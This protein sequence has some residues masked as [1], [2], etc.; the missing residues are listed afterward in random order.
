MIELLGTLVLNRGDLLERMIA[1][2]DYPIDKLA[3]VQNSAAEDVTVAVNK[4]CQTKHKFINSIYVDRP[5]RNIGCGP[6]WNTIIKAFPECTHWL[7]A[8]NDHVFLPGDLLKFHKM[9]SAHPTSFITAQTESFSAF[10]LPSA[11]VDKVGLF[12]ENIWPIYC[13]DLDYMTRLRKSNIDILSIDS[14]VGET[15]NGSWTIRSNQTY[16]AS[17]NKTQNSNNEYMQRKWG[18][19]LEFN[20]PFNQNLPI[21]YWAYNHARRNEHSRYWQNFEETANKYTVQEKQNGSSLESIVKKLNLITDKFPS[22]S[23]CEK[24]YQT[25]LEPYRNRNIQILEIG[26]DQGGGLELFANYLPQAHVLGYDINYQG[27]LEQLPSLYKNITVKL[28]N[29]YDY[30]ALSITPACDII[31][32]SG[33]HVLESQ[34]FFVKNY[35]L[36]LK[37]GGMLIVESIA[38]DNNLALIKAHVPFHLQQYVQVYDFRSNKKSSDDLL[39]VIQLPK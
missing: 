18:K 22:H 5:F 7:I 1:S 17:N 39:L 15:R 12:D 27:K 25:A 38:N 32:D 35:S 33:P 14:E 23:Y 26:C 31:I 6:G 20:T 2:I 29:A 24:F 9:I 34:M 10:A 36:K 30:S 3:I 19:N 16:A 8:N 21:S 13:E 28:L 11:I 37:K 4:I